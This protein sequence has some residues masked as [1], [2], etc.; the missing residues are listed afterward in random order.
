M[1]SVG[2]LPTGSKDPFALRRAALGVIRTVLVSNLPFDLRRA[3]DAA[4]PQSAR[5]TPDTDLAQMPQRLTDFFIDRME[6]ALL[7]TGV[8]PGVVRAVIKA[9]AQELRISTIMRLAQSLHEFLTTE[10]GTN[11]LAGYKRAANI[12]KAEDAK[13]GPHS[14]AALDPASLAHPAEQALGAALDH[15]LPQAAAAIEAEDFTAAMTAL[16]SLRAPVDRFFTDLMVN[17]PIP[18]ERKNRLALI[19][20]FRNAVHSVADFSRIEG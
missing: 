5:A 10:D 13:D 2:L 1:F 18:A 11:L 4:A 20:R 8:L 19:V 9:G 14:A 17:S 12:L 7:E 6:Q 15:A 16:A 3:I